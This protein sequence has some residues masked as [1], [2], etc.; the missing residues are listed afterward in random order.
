MDGEEGVGGKMFDAGGGDYCDWIVERCCWICMYGSFFD[1]A[2]GLDLIF[3][4][5]L[6][7]WRLVLQ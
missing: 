5:R 3:L 7:G 6:S 1:D 2:N 4:L